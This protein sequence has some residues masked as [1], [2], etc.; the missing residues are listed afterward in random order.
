MVSE[1]LNKPNVMTSYQIPVIE[2]FDFTEWLNWIRRFKHFRHASRLAKKSVESQVNRLFNGEQSWWHTQ[3]L[4]GR[5]KKYN[6]VRQ[7]FDSH[8][9]KWRN[10]IFEHAIFN[11]CKQENGESVDSFITDLHCLVCYC[12]YGSLHERWLAF[13]EQIISKNAARIRANI[14]VGYWNC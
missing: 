7:K 5:F 6:T 1:A 9:V 2:T 4:R 8:F 11:S 10:V 3:T 12:N 13:V 14:D